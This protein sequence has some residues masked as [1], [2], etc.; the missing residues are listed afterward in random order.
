MYWRKERCSGRGDR[1][2]GV[3]GGQLKMGKWLLLIVCVLLLATKV[4]G[5]LNELAVLWN[6]E[7]SVRRSYAID[8]EVLMQSIEAFC[9]NGLHRL[10]EGVVLDQV[11]MVLKSPAVVGVGAWQ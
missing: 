9:R 2:L 3:L 1:K 8:V 5:D 11:P 7:W 4:N 6:Q 10:D